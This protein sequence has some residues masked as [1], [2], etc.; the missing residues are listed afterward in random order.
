[1]GWE[2][3]VSDGEDAVLSGQPKKRLLPP[4]N[5]ERVST[6]IPGLDDVLCGGFD[7]E[8]LYLVEGEPGTGRPRLRCT[9]CLKAPT[10][11]RK[12]CMSLSRKANGSFVL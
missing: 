9:F 2:R 5:E 6:G 12:A 11:E 10:T 4:M 8:R 7:P 1:M 3:P